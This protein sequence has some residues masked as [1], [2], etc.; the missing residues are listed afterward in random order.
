L[1]IG[2]AEI[3]RDGGEIAI[4]AYG[5]MVYPSVEAAKNLEK[6]GVETTVVNARYVKPLDSEL[7]LAL[8]QSKRLIVTVEEAYLAGGFGSAVMELLEANG[9]LDSVKIVRLGVPDRIVTHGDPKL[10][11]AKY[12]LDADGIYNKVK[13]TIDILEERRA[14]KK[15][16]KTLS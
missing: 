3:L 10:L 8:A 11:L 4:L 9:M 7:I 2:K 12:G 15:R 1:E 5:S 13:E 14:G 16:L 6:D